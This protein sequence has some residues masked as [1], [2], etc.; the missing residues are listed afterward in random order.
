[1]QPF[2]SPGVAVLK[3]ASAVSSRL[4]DAAEKKQMQT[5]RGPKR[6]SRSK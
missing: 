4:T 2:M 5:H 6:A 3:L 1:M